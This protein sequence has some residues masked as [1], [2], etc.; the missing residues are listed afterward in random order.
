MKKD[1][2]LS[3]SN[4][5][6][7]V[8]H[9]PE[10]L[11]L[12]K[13]KYFLAVSDTGQVTAAAR[14]IYVSPA[15]ITTAIRQLED[16][17]GV[18]LFDRTRQGMRLTREGE[19]FRGY[20]EKALLLVEDAANAV[21]NT[22]AIHGDL[23]VAASPVV[24]GYFLPPLLARFRRLFPLIELSLTELCREE[25]EAGII[26]GKLDM[27]V[28]LVSNVRRVKKLG[29]LTLFSSPR[30]LWCNTH[31]RFA[32]RETVSL[33]DIA[34]ERYIQ[35]TL[36]EAEVNTQKFFRRANERPNLFLRTETVEAVRGYV[37][38]GE[39]VTVLSEMLFR[40]WTLE[41][42]RMLSKPVVPAVPCMDIGIIWKKNTHLSPSKRVFV[43][44]FSS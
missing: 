35:L 23:L 8:S 24:H 14:D 26:A 32:G 25:V 38:Q 19:R 43:E 20:C 13:M 9:A 6:H 17:L 37:A 11:T 3:D 36:D 44:F 4:S 7:T 22:S 41:G 10:V 12:R 18:T 33:S 40:P 16:F 2:H 29:M 21:K 31:H 30:T 1:A 5:A 42:D 39:G 28:V 34:Q 15:V 27:G